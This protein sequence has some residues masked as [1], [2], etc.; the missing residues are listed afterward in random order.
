[1]PTLGIHVVIKSI[2]VYTLKHAPTL[3]GKVIWPS[4]ISNRVHLPMVIGNHC[5]IEYNLIVLATEF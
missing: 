2:I 5:I 3:V 4:Q 1:M